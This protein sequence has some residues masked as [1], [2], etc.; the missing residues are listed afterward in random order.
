M[1]VPSEYSDYANVFLE[2]ST[3]ELFEHID[4]N[5]HL[6]NLVN[7]KQP[8]YGPIYSL[9]PMELE[10]LKTY[11]ETNLANSFLRPFQ[12]LV[13]AL[14]PFLKKKDGSLQLCIDY[15][16]FNNLTIKNW[17]PLSLIGKSLDRLG[18]IKHFSRLDLTNAYHRMRIQEGDE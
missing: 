7:D 5:N 18:C 4:I 3:A 10:M 9:G 11:I 17:Y 6:I 1:F 14:I 15:R 2:V 16:D 13:G 8:L 12:S